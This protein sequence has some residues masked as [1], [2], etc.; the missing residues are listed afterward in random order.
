MPLGFLI[1]AISLIALNVNAVPNPF[2]ITDASITDF[3]SGVDVT[4]GG[5]EDTKIN[6]TATFYHVN[7]Q[8]TYAITLSNTSE[9][10]YT[11]NTITDDNE[12]PYLSYSYPTHAGEQIAAGS[13]LVLNVTVT[14]TDSIATPDSRMQNFGVKFFL[15]YEEIAEPEPEPQPEPEPEPQP[16]EEDIVVPNTNDDVVVPDTGANSHKN[17]GATA[18][19]VFILMLVLGII[20]MAFGVLRSKISDRTKVIVFAVLGT[21]A[22]GSIVNAISSKFTFEIVN[23][24]ALKNLLWVDATV[25]GTTSRSIINYG[26]ALALTAPTKG[27]HSFVGWKDSND[28][29]ITTQQITDDIAVEAVFNKNTYHLVYDANGGDGAE[30]PSEEIKFGEPTTLSQNTY[31]RLEIPGCD[32]NDSCARYRF[33]KWTTANGDEYADQDTITVT[34]ETLA[35]GDTITLYANWEQVGIFYFGNGAS[36]GSMGVQLVDAGETATLWAA[37]YGKTGYGFIGW[38]T[39][40][41]GTGT[42][43]GPNEDIVMPDSGKLELYA[44][45]IAPEQNVTMQT[46]DEADYAA[47]AVGTILALEDE[48]DGNV[49]AVAKLANGKW[50]MIEN[51]RLNPADAN[52]TIT[53]ANTN[54]PD[55]DF[56]DEINDSDNW[57]WNGCTNS[58]RCFNIVSFNTH[59]TDTTLEANRTSGSFDYSWYSYGDTY[60]WYTATAGYGVRTLSSSESVTGDICPAGWHLPRGG[61]EGDFAALDIAMGGTGA[62]QATLEASNRWRSFPVNVV[63]SGATEQYDEFGRGNTGRLWAATAPTAQRAFDLELSENRV[64][65]GYP[66]SSILDKRNGMAVRC[67]AEK[68]QTYTLAY[69]INGGES[70][71]PATQTASTNIGEYIFEI[72][73]ETPTW[74]NHTFL[75]WS[76]DP[77]DDSVLF[78]E[79]DDFWTDVTTNTLYAMWEYNCVNICYYGNGDDGTGTAP[80]QTA[81]AGSEAVLIAPDFRRPGYGFIGWNTAADGTGTMYG[82]NETVTVPASGK[83]ELYAIWEQANPTITMQTFNKDDATY[84]AMPTGAVIAL[85]DERDGNTYS[86]AKLAD[87]NWWMIENLRLNPADANTTIT[88]ANTNNPTAEFITDIN[89]NYKGNTS[90]VLWKNCEENS[91]ACMDQV[92]VGIGNIDQNNAAN[93]NATGQNK[94]WNAYGAMY[95]WYTATAG[96][97]TSSLSYG[98]AAGDIC[99]A[100]WHLPSGKTGG[101]LG[102]L[103]IALGGTGGKQQNAGAQNRN[104]RKYPTNLVYGGSYDA[105]TTNSRG[106][107]ANYWASE[108]WQSNR[109]GAYSLEI[110]A[111]VVYPTETADERY[112]GLAVRCLAATTSFNLDYDASAGNNAP[113]AQSGMGNGGSYTFTISH[114]EPTRDGY[115]FAG[116]TTTNGGTTVEYHPGDEITVTENINT[117]YAV[118][119]MATY[120]IYYSYNT[121]YLSD[122]EFTALGLPTEF[123]IESAD[124]TI[125]AIT[126]TGYKFT[127]WE[128]YGLVGANNQTIVIPTGSYNDRYYT[129]HIEP[130]TYTIRFV[131]HCND[132]MGDWTGVRYDEERTIYTNVAN[133]GYD[134]VGFAY[135]E[136]G[137]IAYQDQDTIKNLTTVDGDIVTFHLVWTPH[138]YTIVYND[139]HNFYDPDD[140]AI[141][142]SEIGDYTGGTFLTL[143]GNSQ[144]MLYNQGAYLKELVEDPYGSYSQDDYVKYSAKIADAVRFKYWSDK[145]DCSNGDCTV[146]GNKDYI[147]NPGNSF[148]NSEINLYAQWDLIKYTIQYNKNAPAGATIGGLE[149]AELDHRVSALVPYNHPAV[150]YEPVGYIFRGFSNAANTAYSSMDL[151]PQTD[152]YLTTESCNV[153]TETCQMYAIWEPVLY[154]IAYDANGGNGEA[155]TPDDVRYDTTATIKANTFTRDGY[156]FVGWST[157]PNATTAEYTPG[158]SVSN[159]A[160]NNGDTV[161]LYAIWTPV[162]YTITYG[163]LTD[164]ELTELHNPTTYKITDTFTLRV[165]ERTGY[166]FTGWT[167]SNGDTPNPIITFI[168]F[169][170][171]R[172]YNAN[173]LAHNYTVEFDKNAAGLNVSG[174]MDSQSFTYDDPQALSANGYT[175]NTIGKKF[176]GWNT[177]QD[178]SGNHYDDEEEVVNLTDEKNGTV[179]LYAE[180]GTTPYRVVFDKNNDNANGAM[181]DVVVGYGEWFNLPTNGFML[182]D[183]KLASWNTEPDGSGRSY[184][185]EAR[186]INLD[187]DGTVTLYAQWR[188]VESI[189][190][191]GTVVNNK[192]KGLVE[193]ASTIT[194]I[195]H[196]V[197]TPENLDSFTSDNIVSA[198]SSLDPIYVWY[199]NGTVYY[200]SI[201]PTPTLNANSN[202]LFSGFSA[203]TEIDLSNLDT[204]RLADMSYM[205]QGDSSLASIDLS[206]FETTNITSLAYTFAQTGLTSVDLSNFN[207]PN[208]KS[209]ACMFFRSKELKNVTFGPNFNT[210]NV[211]DMNMMFMETKVTNLDLSMFNTSQVKNMYRLFRGCSELETINFGNNFDTSNVTT[212]AEMFWMNSK[213]KS[214]DVSTWNTGKVTSMGT[215]FYGCSSIETLEFGP[216]FDTSNVTSMDQMF[217]NMSS[218]TELD[219]SM[220]NT[221]NV[222]SM[223]NMFLYDSNLEKITFGPNFTT[224]SVTTMQGMF[225]YCGKL[226][227]LDLTTFDTKN[228]TNMGY[229]FLDD[230][231]LVT[232]YATDKFVVDQVVEDGENSLPFRSNSSIVGGLGSTYQGRGKTYAHIDGGSENPGYFTDKS[233]LNIIYYKNNNNATGTMENQLNNPANTDV[234]LNANQ[235]GAPVGAVFGGWNTKPDGS[236]THYDDGT[237]VNGYGLLRLYAEWG[238]TPYTVVFDK[239]AE[240][241]TGTMD[242]VVKEFGE[243]FTLPANGF[244]RTG[245]GFLGWNTAVNGS[246]RHYDDQATVVNLDVDGTVTLYAEWVETSGVFN[247]GSKFNTAIKALVTEDHTIRKVKKSTNAPAQNVATTVVSTANSY[248]P[249]VAWF[250]EDT[251]TIY[252]WTEAEDIFLNPDASS[253]FGNLADV[254]EIDVNGFSTKRVTNMGSMFSGDASLTSLDLSGWD[255]GDVTN[256]S[257]MFRGCIALTTLNVANWNTSNVTNMIGVFGHPTWGERGCESLTTLDLSG[258]DT[259]NVTSMQAMFNGAKNLET[260][261]MTN[262]STPK[263]TDMSYM[264]NGCSSLKNVDATKFNPVAVTTAEAMFAGC[265]SLETLNVS[266]WSTSTIKNMSSMFAGC[267]SLTTLDVSDW[268]TIAVTNMSNMFGG[269]SY[270]GAGCESLTTLNV[271][272]W[273]TDNV[274][275][276]SSMFQGCTSLTTLDVSEWNTS[277]VTNM[278]GMFGG[279]EYK[280][281][282]ESLTSLDL[283]HFNT[284]NVTNMANMF[285]GDKSLTSL[286][287]THFNTENVTNMSYMFAGT[288]FTSLDVTHLDTSKVT[289]MAGMF[290]GTDIQSLDLSHFDTSNVT[291]MNRMFCSA[292]GLT[293]LDLSALNTKKVTDIG[294]WVYEAKNLEK[295]YVGGNTI[296]TQANGYAPFFDTKLVGGAGTRY[297]YERIDAQYARIDDPANGTVGYFTPVDAIYVNYDANGGEGTMV[298]HWVSTDPDNNPYNFDTELRDNSDDALTNSGYEFIGWDTDPDRWGYSGEYVINHPEEFDTPITLYAQW[299]EEYVP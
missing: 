26:E 77:N 150:Y 71:A 117:L 94:S 207:T 203:V 47:S 244:T 183:H 133:M 40:E 55:S 58:N 192:I 291:S 256:I 82:P 154:H 186:V 251:E 4:I 214:L 61:E 100:G 88:A 182:A 188:D 191:T 10:D 156:E 229:M 106:N 52:T 84:A 157:D 130:I 222:V 165:A 90:A 284:A 201:D 68:P 248:Y 206:G 283:T 240:D 145:A 102:T 268:N 3:S 2:K 30:M 38:N 46:F 76:E 64:T 212:M 173:Y 294:F 99:P 97:G 216:N 72:S 159:L 62:D 163:G 184:G 296:L 48:R 221:G 56:I 209:L 217:R 63:Y 134:L 69:E 223:A 45:W 15:D 21:L 175:V 215:M 236:G 227:E 23:D 114:D 166:T 119:T 81:A 176:G 42:T 213:L 181:S 242:D 153:N 59:N 19:P 6:S 220:F 199:D 299:E 16:E 60:N 80:R 89:D 34:D 8:V 49:Y 260:I 155:I 149:V 238:A 162:E 259:S 83:L 169:T 123:T 160:T 178:L 109:I 249:I 196:Y 263:V 65:P 295:I 158:Q 241:A 270:N 127:G 275:N 293:E 197:G 122:S 267:K 290:Y 35:D 298:S 254:T 278:S 210:E 208:L 204:S 273:K 128:G 292:R 95:N 32:T 151:Y 262:W 53:A 73:D 285:R 277:N 70:A 36:F 148:M 289:T 226:T 57:V 18:N 225:E 202:K 243:T 172:T 7:D 261:I 272:G 282:C 230:T 92:S 22:T 138:P 93:Y 17:D 14:Y 161:S 264:F 239:N 142:H 144:A 101:D 9:K 279:T 25:D 253:M 115:N 41:D 108:I 269:L 218:L 255:T 125:P 189:F 187:V 258:W 116:W 271:S 107:Y 287:V 98:S 190:H 43:Y 164:D 103:D 135:S 75:G 136:N 237:T 13:S 51:L 250:D 219:L 85:R 280:K 96:N 185:D 113:A 247:T 228:V 170:G 198:P 54:N 5:F 74:H 120:H 33:T 91:A 232:V 257:Y 27:G 139:S 50:W 12:N 252:W 231:S 20:L 104:W 37:N 143:V 118:W 246:G 24:Y 141:I 193:D 126:K 79:G 174:S 235:Y 137:E 1:T 110:F 87:G 31:T 140:G 200:W 78:D 66:N 177:E 234:Q 286:D 124:I 131:T 233:K 167:G 152:I 105:D 28:E 179:T 288:T 121:G 297:A 281:G 168:N 171:D 274:T 245:F 86:I 132:T 194:S 146:W 44:K 211:T 147:Y 67:I 29:M 39:S 180:W 224:E 111:S 205:F 11:I 266:T 265:S 112:L 129:A 195:R 276:M